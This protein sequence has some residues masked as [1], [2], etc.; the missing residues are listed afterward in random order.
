MGHDR[1]E[2]GFNSAVAPP[3]HPQNLNLHTNN[4]KIHK[5][6]DIT[7]LCAF[8]RFLQAADPEVA[9]KTAAGAE[10]FRTAAEAALT[11]AGL[12]LAEGHHIWQTYR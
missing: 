4:I 2:Y 6:Y 9:G 5:L 3:G 11:A 10:V 1:A 8:L 7:V 12:H